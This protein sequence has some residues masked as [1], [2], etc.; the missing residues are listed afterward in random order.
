ML[1]LLLLLGGCAAFN[2]T[3]ADAPQAAS[4]LTQMDPRPRIAVVLGSGGPRGYAHVGTIKALESAGI[5]PDL[6][7]GSSVGALIGSFWANGLNASAIEEKAN[8]GGPLML[9]D[10]SPFADRGWIHGQRLQ[11]YVAGQLKVATLEALPKRMIVIATARDNKQPAL[12][13][14]GNIAVA[15]RASSAVPKVISPVGINGVEYEDADESL[16]L[17]VKAARDAGAQFV[18]AVDVTARDGSAPAGT[19]PEWLAK[20]AKRRARIVPEVAL[21]DFVIHPDMGYVASPFRSFFDKAQA[22]GEAETRARLPELLTLLR[23]RGLK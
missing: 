13:T 21:A 6:I 9:F 15:V 23:E 1:M 11:N 12:F 7:V 14:R 4:T 22:A 19:S 10:I 8:S 3:A 2:Y 18:I 20:D 16:P 17:A 5:E